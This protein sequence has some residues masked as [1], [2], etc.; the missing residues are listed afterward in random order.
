VCVSPP[1]GCQAPN[2]RKPIRLRCAIAPDPNV[3]ERLKLAAPPRARGS[4]DVEAD[5]LLREVVVRVRHLE[6][7]VREAAQEIAELVA[8]VGDDVVAERLDV[9]AGRALV[10]DGRARP[11][12]VG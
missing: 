8:E 1:P 10:V 5:L 9:R 12:R 3:S 7:L 6:R 2:E 11:V 4:G